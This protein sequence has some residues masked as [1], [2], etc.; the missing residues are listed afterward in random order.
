VGTVVDLMLAYN[1]DVVSQ[2]RAYICCNKQSFKLTTSSTTSTVHGSRLSLTTQVLINETTPTKSQPL[3]VPFIAEFSLVRI[4]QKIFTIPKTDNQADFT[5]INGLRVLSLF[6]VILGHSLDFGLNFSNNAVNVFSWTQ[7]LV[8]VVIL[9]APLSV[10][11]FFILSGF[12][13]AI[14]FTRQVENNKSNGKPILSTRLFFMYYIHRYFRLTP[15]FMLV[16]LVSVNLT[17]YFGR[18]P[19][20]PSL[21][22]FEPEG[23]SKYWW[24]SLLY[25]NNLIKPDGMCLGVT[26]YLANDMQFHW[27]AP[28]ALVP[29]VLKRKGISF[30]VVNLFILTS[31]ICT[32]VILIANPTISVSV[33]D[34]AVSHSDVYL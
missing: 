20:F 27:V 19:L 4:L 25:V 7:K 28:L 9:N 13:T 11:T 29:F 32:A 15:T 16:V 31:I 8:F 23:C 12:L 3:P 24:T 14:L 21:H 10:D 34:F 6:L 18:G 1:I 26:W 5:F 2:V 33:T 22:G 30:L 17:A